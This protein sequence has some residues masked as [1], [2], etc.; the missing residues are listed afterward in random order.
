MNK[1]KI[2]LIVLTLSFIY[3]C[4]TYKISY[5]R[6]KIIKKIS[7]NYSIFLDNEII[8]FGNIYLD[9]DNIKN[10]IIR[11]SEKIINVSQAKKMNFLKLD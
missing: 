11:K 3:G 5:N 10:V 4:T 1:I 8:D 9:K 7:E 2:I 6:N